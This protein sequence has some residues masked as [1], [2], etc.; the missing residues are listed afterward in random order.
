MGRLVAWYRARGWGTKLLLAAATGFLGLLALYVSARAVQYAGASRT[1]AGLFVPEDADLVIRVADGAARWNDLQKT[2]LWR[3]FTRKMQKDAGVRTTLNEILASS[4]APTLDDLEDRR[5]LDRNTLL[6]E[7]SLVRF[8]G[9]DLAVAVAG[10]KFCVATRI[11]PWDFMLLPGLQLFPGLA[12]AERAEAGGAPMLRRGKLCIGIQGAIVVVSNDPAMLASAL[13][14]R[15]TPAVPT[16]LLRASLRA[17]SFRDLLRGFPAGGLLAVTDIEKCTRIEI[18]VEV[19]GADLVVRATGE[20]LEPVRPDPAPVDTVRMIPRNGL[21]AVVT[22]VETGPYWEW[23][24]RVTD[25]RSRGGT[26]VD[27]FARQNFRDILEVLATSRFPEEVLPKLDGPVSVLFGAS[28]G[29]NG[30][31]YAA[32][33]LYL[34]SSRPREAAESLQAMI[35]KATSQPNDHFRPADSEIG[36]VRIRSYSYHPDVLGWNNYLCACYAV[37]NDALIL[38]NN[39]A[40]LMDTLRCLANEEP[41]MAIQLPYEQAQRRLLQLGLRRVMVSGA[42]ESLFLYGPAIRQGL[43]GFYDTVASRAIDSPAYRIKLRQ[44]LETRAMKEGQPLGARALD[45]QVDRVLRER[46]REM[47]DKLRARA[48]ILD[49]LKWIALQVEK[50]PGGMKLEL[51]IELK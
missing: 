6:R 50:V 45:E 41:S 33:A 32:A 22:N 25:R 46:S 5:W 2:E 48:R 10:E 43:E 11:G 27:Q 14:R 18:D 12:G 38:A 3:N 9:R 40:F 21:G 34:R 17:E 26:A 36:G 24:R 20:G 1:P 49:Y 28:E 51:A 35:D 44:D 23:L 37:T 13:K 42:A 8:A 7:E 15:G 47:E 39:L 16:G 29:E 31:T 30:R 19:S 4:G